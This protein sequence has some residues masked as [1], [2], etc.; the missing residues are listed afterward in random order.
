MSLIAYLFSIQVPFALTA[1]LSSLGS[2]RFV[3]LGGV[4][5]LVSGAISMGVG[6]YFSTLAERE[7]YLHRA[8]QVRQRIQRSC[9]KELT[10]EVVEI[11]DPYGAS[12][13]VASLLSAHLM[14]AEKVAVEDHQQTRIEESHSQWSRI[15]S[16]F[17]RFSPSRRAAAHQQ[18]DTSAEQEKRGLTQ[19]LVQVGGGLEAVPLSRVYLSAITIG[20]SYL[21]GGLIPLLPYLIIKRVRT[22]LFV[23]IG[24][25]AALL[26][27]FGI[28]KQHFSGAPTGAKGYAFGAIST[29][30]VGGVAAA[31]SYGIV[32]AIESHDQSGPV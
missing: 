2:S 3:V 32:H 7:H 17:L 11:L 27:V 12:Y 13:T 14:N 5:E 16:R 1:G 21:V 8:R 31:A 19:F 29:L 10:D 9:P 20:I 4:A 24:I 22:A 30:L 26:V 28:V 15:Q 25:T 18:E 23:S 6:G